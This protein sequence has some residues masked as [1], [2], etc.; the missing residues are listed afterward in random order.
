MHDCGAYDGKLL[1]VP[2]ANPRQT[3]IKSI[4]QIAPNQLEDVAEFLEL[5]KDLMEEQFKLMVG[6]ILMWLKII[7]N[8]TPQ[9]KKNFKVLKKLT[10]SQ[11]N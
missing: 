7:K 4:N 2:T 8:C 1:C 10:I 9:K 6:G 11:G 5:V 3:N